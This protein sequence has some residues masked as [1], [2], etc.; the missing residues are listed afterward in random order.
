MLKK[1]EKLQNIHQTV[2]SGYWKEGIWLEIIED[3]NFLYFTRSFYYN[4]YILLIL[5]INI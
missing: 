1:R 2:N 4:D 3:F 5:Y